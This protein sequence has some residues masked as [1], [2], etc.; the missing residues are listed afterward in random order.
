MLNPKL[1]TVTAIQNAWAPCAA[2][3]VNGD[4]Y[5][6]TDKTSS[7]RVYFVHFVQTSLYNESRVK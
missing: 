4:I 6:W 5:F 7:L 2:L 1:E 3:H